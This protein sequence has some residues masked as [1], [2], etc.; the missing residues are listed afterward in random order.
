MKNRKHTT[1][2]SLSFSSDGIQSHKF[3]FENLADE[4]IWWREEGGAIC[5]NGNEVS[6]FRHEMRSQQRK[7]IKT[8]FTFDTSLHWENGEFY[9]MTKKW[10]GRRGWREVQSEKKHQIWKVEN[11]ISPTIQKKEKE[12]SSFQNYE[13]WILR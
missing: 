6:I 10:W 13:R 12:G 7:L 2:R 1:T 11:S 5:E 8:I 3:H 9:S 4:R